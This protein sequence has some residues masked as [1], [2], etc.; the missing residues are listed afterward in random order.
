MSSNGDSDGRE[1]VNDLDALTMGRD[2]AQL[3]SE[4]K[5]ERLYVGLSQADVATVL[6]VSR[7]AIS[8]IETGRRR[9]TSVELK[10]LAELFGTSVDK[11]LGRPQTEDESTLAL[12]RATKSLS[13]SDKEQVLRFAEFLRGAGPAPT[14]ASS[15]DQ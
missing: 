2:E 8:A 12:F 3:A 5:R 15:P 6:N 13:Q 9:V 10:K 11:L 7:A 14:S 1:R 4:I